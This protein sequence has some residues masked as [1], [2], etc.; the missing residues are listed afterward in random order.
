MSPEGAQRLHLHAGFAFS[1]S[2]TDSFAPN[3]DHP[4]HEILHQELTDG[5][6]L[7]LRVFPPELGFQ[8][9]SVN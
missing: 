2:G 4:A 7:P 8:S 6:D 1:D 3:L 5:K 9:G